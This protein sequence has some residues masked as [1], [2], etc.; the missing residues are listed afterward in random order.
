MA[1]TIADLDELKAA[2]VKGALSIGH[3]DK[4]VQY[5]SEADLWMRIRK[6]SAALGVPLPGQAFRR[7]FGKFRKGK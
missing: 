6:L 7:S 4:R 2:Y 1:W 5:G 3:G